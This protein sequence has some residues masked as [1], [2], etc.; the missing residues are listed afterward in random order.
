MKFSTIY[1]I[2]HQATTTAH[3]F[4]I[5]ALSLMCLILYTIDTKTTINK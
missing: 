5:F 3:S 4:F 1:K 2:N